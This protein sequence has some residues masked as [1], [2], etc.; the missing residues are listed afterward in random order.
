MTPIIPITPRGVPVI[1]QP[2]ITPVRAKGMDPMITSGPEKDSNWEAITI[3]TSITMSTSRV[4]RS[5]KISFWS[6]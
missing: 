5:E 4:M 3:Y 6:S 1:T 2:S